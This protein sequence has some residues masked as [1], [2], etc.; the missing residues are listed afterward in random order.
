LGGG[1]DHRPA[2]ALLAKEKFVAR[3]ERD[4]PSATA[5]FLDDFEA[6]IAICN[7][8]SCDLPGQTAFI[9]VVVR[10]STV[11]AVLDCTMVRA[12]DHCKVVQAAVDCRMM[13]L[14]FRHTREE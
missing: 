8:V 10:C 6:C 13:V 4:Y 14:V 2:L 7:P 11:E 5:C 1:V 9:E 3:Y 12:V